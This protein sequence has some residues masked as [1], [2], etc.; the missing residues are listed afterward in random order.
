[1]SVD[2]DAAIA[3]RHAQ[4][5]VD[6]LQ[7][8]FHGAL[9]HFDLPLDLAG[10]TFQLRAWAWLRTIPFAQ[11]RSYLQEALALGGVTY[12]RAV[13][14]ANGRNPVSIIVPCHR[15]IGADGKLVGY[16]GGLERKA[17]LLRHERGPSGLFG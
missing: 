14:M 17:W 7:A 15:V 11:T 10:T 9:R 3:A 5:A 8:Y 2:G 6:Q 16:G 12:S 1:M 13:G 4:L